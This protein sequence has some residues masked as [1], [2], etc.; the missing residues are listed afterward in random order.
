M[1][2]ALT[3]CAAKFA[4]SSAVMSL[5]KV[6]ICSLRFTKKVW[7]SFLLSADFDAP[8]LWRSRRAWMVTSL[9]DR[10]S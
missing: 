10:A 3:A 1:A 9:D 7:R 5:T 8:L 4:S 2:L 6:S